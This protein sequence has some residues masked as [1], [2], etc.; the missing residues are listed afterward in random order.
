M[1][2]WSGF[3]LCSHIVFP[4]HVPKVEPAPVGECRLWAPCLY[5]CS[6]SSEHVLRCFCIDGTVESSVLKQITPT[7]AGIQSMPSAKVARLQEDNACY[8]CL[9]EFENRCQI[10]ILPCGHVFHEECIAAWSVS[11]SKNA[12]TCPVCRGSFALG[13]TA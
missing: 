1:S 11:P 9:N 13:A 3:G 7:Q 10:A 12:G 6:K 5:G 4:Q 2:S 8:C